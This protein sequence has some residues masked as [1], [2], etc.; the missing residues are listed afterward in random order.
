MFCNLVT[1]NWDLVE[2]VQ[3]DGFYD[4]CIIIRGTVCEAIEQ[5]CISVIRLEVS[6][7]DLAHVIFRN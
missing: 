7:N 1:I 2:I 4:I 5:R 3:D 6:R